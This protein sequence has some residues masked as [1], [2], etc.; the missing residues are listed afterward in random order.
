M[1][2]M[3]IQQED[4]CY[5]WKDS[6]LRIDRSD[7]WG[8]PEKNRNSLLRYCRNFLAT[9]KDETVHVVYIHG[10][11]GLGK[12]FVCRQIA[13]SLLDSNPYKEQVYTILVGLQW[14]RSFAEHLKCMADQ[15]EEQAKVQELFP[16]FHMAYY[17]YKMKRAEDVRQEEYSTGWERMREKTPL[18]LVTGAIGLVAP[19]ETVSAAIDLANEGYKWLLKM[20][21]DK[22]YKELAHRLE[23]MDERELRGQM[24]RFFAEDFR[25]IFKNEKVGKKCIFLLDTVES[26]RYQALRCADEEDYLE[27][28]AGTE[29]LFRLLP[30]CFWMLFGREEI[31]WKEYDPKWEE[32]FVSEKLARPEDKI[33]RE[34]LLEKLKG[35]G[36]EQQ[37][38]S[39]R[40]KQY[41]KFTGRKRKLESTIGKPQEEDWGRS[42]VVEKIMEQ[43]QG[44]PL[45]IEHCVDVYFRMW[46][47]K[48]RDGRVTDQNKA[49]DYRPSDEDIQGLFS[50]EKGKD[51]QKLVSARFLQ[52]YTLQEREVLYTLVCLG[53]WTDDILLNLLWKGASG[54]LL[55]YEELCE[56]SFIQTEGSERTIQGLMLDKIMDECRLQLKKK[57]FLD[58][59]EQMRLREPDRTYWLLY[60][61]AVRIA[62]TGVCG[63]EEWNLLGEQ[64]VR[65]TGYL[66]VYAQFSDLYEACTHLLDRVGSG[67][68]CV[69]QDLSCAA[70]IGLYFAAVFRRD[71]EQAEAKLKQI[72][73]QEGFAGFSWRIWQSAREASFETGAY[74]QAYEIAVVLEKWFSGHPVKDSYDRILQQKIE[75]MW[76]C[77]EYVENDEIEKEMKKL[78]ELTERRCSD[79]NQAKKQNAMLWVK[80]YY[81]APR[82][83]YD[84]EDC[85]R[86]IG[87]Y[88]QDYRACCTEQELEEDYM[89]SVF[90]VMREEIQITG[91]RRSGR[92]GWNENTNKWSLKGLH[93]LDECYGTQAVNQPYACYL[94]GRIHP[95]CGLS[96]EDGE[97]FCRFFELIYQRFYQ[98][99]DWEM[100]HYLHDICSIWGL[101]FGSLDER[102]EC[103]LVDEVV[104]ELEQLMW[105]GITFL[106]N[107]SKENV[108]NQLQ[109]VLI[110]DL[111]NS[112]DPVEE[113]IFERN[114]FS[115][116]G[117]G[118]E[119]M[120]NNQIL[121]YFLQKAL[122]AFEQ[123]CTAVNKQLLLTLLRVIPSSRIGYC[124]TLFVDME[125]PDGIT[126]EERK[127]LL[128]LFNFCGI[129]MTR[130]IQAIE[131]SGNMTRP[132][133][134]FLDA[135]C[136]WQWGVDFEADV[137]IMELLFYILCRLGEREMVDQLLKQIDRCLSEDYDNDNRKVKFWF[138]LL[139]TVEAEDGEEMRDLEELLC[140]RLSNTGVSSSSFSRRICE[141]IAP[142]NAS[143][144]KRLKKHPFVYS[145]RM[146][147]CDEE[148]LEEEFRNLLEEG[149]T[150]E[151]IARAKAERKEL[152]YKNVEKF[153][154]ILLYYYV[155]ESWQNPVKL[156]KTVQDK[157][158][159]SH[160]PGGEYFILRMYAYLDDREKFI[161]HYQEYRKEI[162]RDLGKRRNA[163][164][165]AEFLHMADYV[166]SLG[167]KELMENYCS[168]MADY[169]V[170]SSYITQIVYHLE[171][172]TK[173]VSF[174]VVWRREAFLKTIHDLLDLEE[175]DSFLE[176]HLSPRERMELFWDS[177]SRHPED[178]E[179]GFFESEYY[180]W[181]KGRFGDDWDDWLREQIP[182]LYDFR[183]KYV[184]S[185]RNKDSYLLLL[186]KAMCKIRELTD[187]CAEKC[188]D[189]IS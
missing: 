189:G 46:N 2:I 116:A 73:E 65:G 155:A 103:T 100:Y 133:F 113:G 81:Y 67:H 160:L 170:S 132:E 27:W 120:M 25:N 78:C 92:F 128:R 93:I 20:R 95:G 139:K 36:V 123:E 156:I 151:V 89:S 159:E 3:N 58:I 16:R 176:I 99:G 30:D 7:V 82:P 174:H 80:Y 23:A 54:S 149:K 96:E 85:A 98:N 52:Y 63:T 18:N 115:S 162:W 4:I 102:A 147:T 31:P 168:D 169:F 134:D 145:G 157:K 26:M 136:G 126:R 117:M 183:E 6:S 60:H 110:Y 1:K 71:T 101:A 55:I 135:V 167:D 32:S 62:G 88:I 171:W 19:L 86:M 61:S 68:G 59:L 119:M 181:M 178:G 75:L 118:D 57:L 17:N 11:G 79:D 121:L 172:L 164:P 37:S 21:D 51:G 44:Y 47:K 39:G 38:E 154:I 146:D 124:P 35:E 41:L 104:A 8:D 106:S 72:K 163:W 161:Q 127:L 141:Q 175:A 129:D 185:C 144:E 14:H 22:K 173:Y 91:A 90:E 94:F 12:T 182:R 28:L 158:Q 42:A 112:L 83:D 148:A 69:E 165:H 49:E 114:W 66:F 97:V 50:D 77:G 84:G 5:R 45:A 70:E 43:T 10:Q 29:G 188:L 180:L 142:Y 138:A 131:F 109:F 87:E 137:R 140:K 150:E 13:K 125:C 166:F 107:L 184:E 108:Q 153:P 143:C 177:W 130:A 33:I 179:L 74:R 9:K 122:G 24:V 34:Y 48:L 53:T 15:L 56:T 111:L 152:N 186:D 76:D 40:G 64:F 105:K 187:S